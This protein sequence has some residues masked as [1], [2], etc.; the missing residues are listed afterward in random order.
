MSVRKRLVQSTEKQLDD[1]W[2]CIRDYSDIPE[3][4]RAAEELYLCSDYL[5]EA[6]LHHDDNY[7]VEFLDDICRK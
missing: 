1:V 3:D 7:W 4:M 2:D 5:A 6:S